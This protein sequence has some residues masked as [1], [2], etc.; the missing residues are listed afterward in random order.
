MK[1]LE[2]FL[3]DNHFSD[4]EITNFGNDYFYNVPAFHC[5]G[6]ILSLTDWHDIDVIRKYCRKHRL[7]ITQSMTKGF[8][9]S[10][11]YIVWILK[12]S[13]AVKLNLYEDWMQTSVNA[14]ERRLHDIKTQYEIPGSYEEEVCKDIM[15]TFGER[16]LAE[17]GA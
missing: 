15:Q 9:G 10:Y 8:P 6:I 13:D 17:L 1:R 16:L 5:K 7:V 2:T 14:I 4:Y 12:A 3:Q 11:R